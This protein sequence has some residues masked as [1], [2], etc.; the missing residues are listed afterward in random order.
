[1]QDQM[2]VL[3]SLANA[4]ETLFILLGTYELLDM[5]DLSGQ[6]G[7]RSLSIHFRR[8]RADNDEVDVFRTAVNTF[9]KFMPLKEEPALLDEVDFLYIGSMGCIGILKGWLERALLL[10]LQAGAATV[11]RDH[12][13]K[14]IMPQRK[15]LRITQEIAFGEKTV[16]ETDANEAQIRTMLG[17]PSLHHRSAEAPTINTQQRKVGIRN[18]HRDPVGTDDDGNLLV[19]Q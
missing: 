5:T 1:M 11:T 15:R 13:E 2:D 18:P 6:L 19:T 7:R 16:A 4:T 12:L 10:A 9:A 8:Y 17:L 3:K 14:T